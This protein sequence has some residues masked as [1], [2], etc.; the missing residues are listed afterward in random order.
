MITVR[1][2]RGLPGY[3]LPVTEAVFV[4]GR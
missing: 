2:Q 3:S 4:G 1:C